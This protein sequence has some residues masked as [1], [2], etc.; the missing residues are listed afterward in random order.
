MIKKNI[1][2]IN[3]GVTGYYKYQFKNNDIF[4]KNLVEG[5][6]YAMKKYQNLYIDSQKYNIN[7]NT[8]DLVNLNDLDCIIIV[9][10][11][12][13]FDFKKILKMNIPIFLIIEECEVV[14]GIS[15][16]EIDYDKFVKVFTMHDDKVE[17]SSK[18][19][20]FNCMSYIKNKKIDKNIDNKKKFLTLIASNK[21]STHINEL[22]SER[23]KVI[24]WYEKNQ[25]EKFDLYGRGWDRF[26]FPLNNNSLRFLNSK[27][28]YFFQK[29]F[30]TKRPSWQGIVDEKTATLKQYKFSLAFDNAKNYR[31]YILEKIFDIFESS[32]VP[33]YFGAPNIEKHIPPNCFIDYRNF[34]S[35]ADM[36]KYLI[37]INDK[38]YIEILDN[39]ENF[40]N[41]NLSYQFGSEYFSKIVIKEILSLK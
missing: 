24:S 21:K 25:P 35:I 10:P 17:S 31:G 27:K 38:Q 23:L 32:S 20:K 1:K 33:I 4:L 8:L 3:V 29:L 7:M 5:G 30:S 28:F 9:E 13:R 15:L 18:F 22:Y 40:L 6:N 26:V 37:N 2:K 36:H 39:I 34:P 19:I 41:S 11:L 16:D 12:N 14:S